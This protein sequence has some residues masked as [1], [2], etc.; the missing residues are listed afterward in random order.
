MQLLF[1]LISATL[2]VLF[3]YAIGVSKTRAKTLA[4]LNKFRMNLDNEIDKSW[5]ETR[6]TLDEPVIT[7]E[8]THKLAFMKGVNSILKYY[9]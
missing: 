1:F 4:N 3:G 5:K 8:E 9:E 2:L 7:K 6:Y